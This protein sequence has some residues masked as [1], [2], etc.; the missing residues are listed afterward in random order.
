MEIIKHIV[1]INLD[2]KSETFSKQVYIDLD[3]KFNSFKQ[4]L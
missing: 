3:S 4:N 1:L 2:S